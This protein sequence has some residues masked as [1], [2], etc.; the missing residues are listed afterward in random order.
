M[1]VNLI[2]GWRDNFSPFQKVLSI[3]FFGLMFLMVLFLMFHARVMRFDVQRNYT[4]AELKQYSLLTEDLKKHDA[5]K[6]NTWRDRDYSRQI[7]VEKMNRVIAGAKYVDWS[8]YVAKRLGWRMYNINREFKIFPWQLPFGQ[9]GY[10][11]SIAD[12]EKWKKNRIS[13]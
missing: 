11:R 5:S 7:I 12:F 2:D 4:P 9:D 6:F 13:S 10:R 3:S 8:Q 1:S